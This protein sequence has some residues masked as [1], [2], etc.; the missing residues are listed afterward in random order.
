M[1]YTSLTAQTNLIEMAE[2]Y[3]PTPGARRDAMLEAAGRLLSD[4]GMHLTTDG[5]GALQRPL[6]ASRPTNDD[7]G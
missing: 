6:S 2:W 4:F 5:E 3:F 7:D 1:R